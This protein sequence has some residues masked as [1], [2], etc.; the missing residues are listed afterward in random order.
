MKV[1]N[2]NFT[3]FRLVKCFLPYVK[4]YWN[5]FVLLD[6]CF[7]FAYVV[8]R[9]VY[10]TYVK[11]FR[12]SSCGLFVKCCYGLPGYFF[13][14]VPLFPGQIVTFH[15]QIVTFHNHISAYLFLKFQLK[16]MP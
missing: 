13:V 7:V 2:E 9:N 6:I 16:C 8:I 1:Q 10:M 12:N 5:F 3:E 4:V 11:A 14:G 15:G